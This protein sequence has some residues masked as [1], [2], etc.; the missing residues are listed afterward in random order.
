[1]EVF[2]SVFRFNMHVSVFLLPEVNVM[3]SLCFIENEAKKP[4]LEVDVNVKAE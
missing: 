2:I 1:V 3:T 4:A